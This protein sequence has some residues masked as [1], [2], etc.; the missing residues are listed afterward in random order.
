VPAVKA[1]PSPRRCAQT[2]AA[3]GGCGLGER[4]VSVG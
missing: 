4:W 1:P 2:A 3:A